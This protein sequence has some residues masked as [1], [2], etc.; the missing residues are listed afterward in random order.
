MIAIFVFA[1][2]SLL[3]KGEDRRI[4]RSQ[5]ELYRKLNGDDSL[6][7]EVN[8][9]IK[10]KQSVSGSAIR[11]AGQVTRGMVHVCLVFV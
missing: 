2:H 11:R 8:L 3:P 7:F 9:L 10:K 1:L 4:R 5:L 6:Q